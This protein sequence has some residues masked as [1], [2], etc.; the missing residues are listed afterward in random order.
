MAVPGE[1][2]GFYEAWSKFG[3]LPWSDLF[4]PAISRCENGFIVEAD[5]SGA[6]QQYEDVMFSDP[7]F[8]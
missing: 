4:Q 5:L 8:K 1:V 3:R 2:R 6:I 7:N